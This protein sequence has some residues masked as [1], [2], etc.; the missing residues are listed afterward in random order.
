VQLETIIARLALAGIGVEARA[1]WR[2]GRPPAFDQRDAVGPFTTL[3]VFMAAP[4]SEEIASLAEGLPGLR[5]H[6]RYPPAQIHM[7]VRN[8]DGVALAGLPSL[9]SQATAIKLRIAR[10]HFTP[11]TLLLQLAPSDRALRDL[12]NQL[13]ELPGAAAPAWAR[14]TL[15]FANVLRLNGPVSNELR[16]GV[17]RAGRKLEGRPVEI[18][19]L[20]LVRTDKVGSP[21]RTQVLGRYALTGAAP[22][23]SPT[24]FRDSV[25]PPE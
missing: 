13:D 23:N 18:H 12:R 14:P 16:S 11:K 5:A 7:T 20:Q 10:L 4:I 2:F 22:K 24:N 17:R 21:E 6:F 15:A 25:R 8:L 1:R 3:V 9:L 19:D